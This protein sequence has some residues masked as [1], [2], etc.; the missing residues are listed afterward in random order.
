MRDLI[1]MGAMV[2]PRMFVSGPGLRTQSSDGRVYG[3]SGARAKE[4]KA[5][6]DAGADWVKIFGST[7]GA[8]TSPASNCPFEEMRAII[9]HTRQATGR[10]PLS[11]PMAHATRSRGHRHARTRKRPDDAT[12]GELLRKKVW[13]VPT[14]NHNQR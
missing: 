11:G 4:A 9:V 10:H 6:L 14:I 3:Y 12:I 2:G 7:G 13:Y 5:V 1:N 8:T